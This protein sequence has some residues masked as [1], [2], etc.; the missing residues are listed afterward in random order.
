MSDQTEPAQIRA[1]R[2]CK[3]PEK[4]INISQQT[5]MEWNIARFRSLLLKEPDAERRTL[6][7]KLLAE[8]QAKLVTHLVN[9]Q[10]GRPA[11]RS[12]YCAWT[13]RS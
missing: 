11:A 1:E 13:H 10:G 3:G 5:I 2:P 12:G 6:L 8:E 4:S 7:F 9:E